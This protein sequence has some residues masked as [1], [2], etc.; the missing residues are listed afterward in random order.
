VGKFS[1]PQAGADNGTVAVVSLK[2]NPEICY[3]SSGT[4]DYASSG[5]IEFTTGMSRKMSAAI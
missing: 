2:P 3:F 1:L 4:S 5:S